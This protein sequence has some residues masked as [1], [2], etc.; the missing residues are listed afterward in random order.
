MLLFKIMQY[1]QDSIKDVYQ[2]FVIDATFQILQTKI[3]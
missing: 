2:L 1:L 3:D